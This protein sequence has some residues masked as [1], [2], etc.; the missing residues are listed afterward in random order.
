MT[1]K[2][3]SQLSS[4]GAVAGTDLFPDVQTVGVGPVKVTAA[5]MATY[6]WTSPAFTGNGSIT[7]NF[8]GKQIYNP[9]LSLTS[10]ASIS[11]DANNGAVATLTLNQVGATLTVSN[12]VAGGTYL[13]FITQGAGGN[14][15]ITTW[16]NFKW[17]G[18]FIPTLSASAGAVD[19]ITGYSDGT[20][21]YANSQLGY[22]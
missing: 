20:F 13:L 14:K 10:G 1:N 21:F 16:T 15:T 17:V 22:A 4:G 6:F 3:I 8:T 12:L 11:W 2:S 9:P 5:Q 19:I 7:G 18:G